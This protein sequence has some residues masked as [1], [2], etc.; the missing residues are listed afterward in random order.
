MI[1][2]VGPKKRLVL[3]PFIRITTSFQ[4]FGFCWRM[5]KGR[6]GESE[7]YRVSHKSYL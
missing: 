1:S 7:S 6:N 4:F 3:E 5:N 2:V